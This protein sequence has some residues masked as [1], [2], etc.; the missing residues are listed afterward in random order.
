MGIPKLNRAK[1]DDHLII[2]FVQIANRAHRNVCWSWSCCHD[3]KWSGSIKNYEI[4][5]ERRDG[6][7]LSFVP[8]KLHSKKVTRK[9][10]E[11]Q[12]SNSNNLRN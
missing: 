10:R 11:N 12:A 8:E 9:N 4:Q 3:E 2:F 6:R 7:R 1:N 5:H